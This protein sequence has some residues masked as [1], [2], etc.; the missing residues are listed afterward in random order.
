MAFAFETESTVLTR[1]QAEHINVRHFSTTEHLRASKFDPQFNLVDSLK[2]VSELTWEYHEDA[3]IIDEGWK[4]GHGQFYLFVFTLDLTVGKDPE[5]FAAKHLAVYYSEKV[6]G[7][8]WE[9]ITAYPFTF[10]YH[11][12]FRSRRSTFR[13]C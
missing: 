10:S 4:Q 6:P 9:I 8:K 7:E 11:S 1:E 13:S 5:G 12:Y 2:A 3:M